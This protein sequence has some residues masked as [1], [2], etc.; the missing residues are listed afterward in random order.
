MRPFV[1]KLLFLL[2]LVLVV[3][4]TTYWQ[5]NRTALTLTDSWTQPNQE[6]S[7]FDEHIRPVDACS[8]AEERASFT[9]PPG[10]EIELFASEPQIG[11]PINLAFDAKGRLWV[12]QSVEYPLA[13]KPGQGRDR[14]TILE[15]RDHDGRADHFTTVLD[16]LNI[17]IG[18]LP[19]HDG[20]VGFSI[21]NVYRFTDA[22]GDDKPEASRRLLGPFGYRDTHGMVNHLTLGFDGWIH[23]CHGFT[24]RSQIAGRDGDSV[25]LVSG[26]TFRFRADGSRVEQTTYGRVNP[27]GLTFDDWGYLYSTDCHSSPLYQLITGADYPT[28]GRPADGI[29][30]APALKPHEAE[31]TALAGLALS[32]GTTFPEPYRNNLFIGDVV[33]SR[34]YRT[35]VMFRG[36]SPVGKSEEDFLRSADPWFRP[37]DV[38]QGPDGALYVADFYNRIIGHYE[39]PLDNPG[40]DHLR[41]RIWRITY[42]GQMATQGRRD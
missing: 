25:T 36:S 3:G 39:V 31:A 14:L 11:K 42:K 7:A 28:F 24:N 26:N 6:S 34:L 9:L 20:A 21:P 13:A 22:D 41:G 16:S 4:C 33:K 10:F 5:R 35:S 23:A 2:T 27:F 32:S 38:V 15:D 12:T 29:G 40:R 18:I 1:D 37:T 30:F 8:P 19:V 17:P